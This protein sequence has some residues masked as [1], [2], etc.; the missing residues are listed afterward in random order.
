MPYAVLTIFLSIGLTSNGGAE[1][2]QELFTADW[3]KIAD[4]QLWVRAAS[5]I[6]FSLSV[7]YGGIIA[8]S[9]YNPR[10]H[11]F[12]RDSVIVATVNR[13]VKSLYDHHRQIFAFFMFEVY[14]MS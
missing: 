9:S 7:C 5:Q 13:K 4:P 8:F 6:F 14:Y 2:I 1:G 3:D 12:L 11:N 10:S